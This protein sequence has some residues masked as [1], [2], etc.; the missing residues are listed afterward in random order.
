MFAA[1]MMIDFWKVKLENECCQTM[2]FAYHHA[3]ASG[4]IFF[5]QMGIVTWVM[6]RTYIDLPLTDIQPRMRKWV[7]G[8]KEVKTNRA[9]IFIQTSRQFVSF[10]DLNPR[11]DIKLLLSFTQVLNFLWR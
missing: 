1:W 6:S 10:T 5:A 7:R 9:L 11:N 8:L 4:D 3:M 2:M